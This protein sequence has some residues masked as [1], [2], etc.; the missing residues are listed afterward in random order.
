MSGVRRDALDWRVIRLS[1]VTSTMDEAAARARGGDPAGT[2]V[3]ADHQTNG[4]GQFGRHWLEPPCTC[5]LATIVLRPA[6]TIAT[7][8]EISCEIAETVAA[9]IHRV[10]GLCPTIKEPNDVLIGGRK[11]C[12]IL[13]QSSIRGDLLEYLLIGIGL[14]VNIPHDDLPVTTSTSLLVETGVEHER[15]LLLDAILDQIRAIPGLC[16]GVPSRGIA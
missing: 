6:M 4:R 3:V 2:I 12:G 7:R 16:E 5:L 15:D 8:P 11:V 13:S 9:A 14:N 10:T 1:E